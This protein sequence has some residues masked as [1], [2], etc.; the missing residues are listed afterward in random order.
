MDSKHKQ[1]NLKTWRFCLVIKI[2]KNRRVIRNMDVIENRVAKLEDKVAEIDKNQAVFIVTLNQFVDTVK[3]FSKSNTKLND[4]IAKLDDTV[5]EV[6]FAMLGMKNE[7]KGNTQDICEVKE[8]V[9][10]LKC[11]MDA[12]E[13]KSKVDLVKLAKDNV[14][15]IVAFGYIVLHA[16]NLIK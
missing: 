1:S 9:G 13:E 6:K 5:T 16:L 11:G 10:E 12:N 2:S 15:A 14:L 3:E 8:E 4:T 7:I